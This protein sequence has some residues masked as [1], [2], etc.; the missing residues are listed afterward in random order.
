MYQRLSGCLLIFISLLAPEYPERDAGTPDRKFS[1]ML[2]FQG[3][4]KPLPEVPVLCYHN[5]SRNGLKGT[6]TITESAF[7]QQ[8]KFLGDNGYHSVLPCDLDLYFSS[9]RKL[10]SKPVMLTFDDSHAEHY[11]IAAP[12]LEKY[13]FKGVF[14]IMTVVLNKPGYLNSGEI[15]S[16]AG[17]GHVIGLHTWDHHLVTSFTE[18]DWDVQITKPK[19]Q[20]EK[21][22][23][24]PVEYFAYPCG[25]WNETVIAELKRRGIK[26]AYQLYGKRSID[27]RYAVRRIIVPGSWSPAALQHSLNVAFRQ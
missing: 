3:P 24:Q 1:D 6:Y 17:G 22:I 8:M 10:P 21:I 23:H 5:I 20:L 9:N 26:G 7:I 11:S 13:G 12:V 4:S 2:F 18:K 15:K 19:M 16:L 14:F 25:V 27:E